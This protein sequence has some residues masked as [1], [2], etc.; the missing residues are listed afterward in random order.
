MATK[1]KTPKGD[2]VAS[3]IMHAF[4]ILFAITC[5]IP[6]ILVIASSFTSQA[7][8]NQF[9]YCF[10][11][12]EFSGAAYKLLFE[13]GTVLPAYG[14]TL[15]V[16]IVGTALSMLVT[17]ACA[18]AISCKS[19]YYRGAIAFFIYFTMLFTGGLV[20]TYLWVTRY[21]HLSDSLWA[22][23]LPSLVNAW[24]LLLMRNFFNGIPEAL[25]ESAKIDGANDIRIL[26]SIILPVSLPGIA[27]VGLFYALAYWNEWYKAL[28]YIHTE[29][30]YPL[31][32]LV[33]QIQ[34]NIQYVQQN[35]A[36]AGV[37]TDGLIPAETVQMATAVVTIGPI[38][39]LYPFL[40]KYFVQGLTV[41]SVKG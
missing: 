13:S 20:P 27:T 41:G 2:I 12:R 24:N 29:W 9:G 34:K 38:V 15:F 11:P 10:W 28:L 1:I 5:I 37:V 21:L 19:M 31:Q 33:M 4:I 3:V 35:A 40:Q 22:L 17:C 32:Y 7:S 14:V 23:I 25:S 18:Y 30:K 26:F 8:L 6:F 16:T 36:Q 39:L